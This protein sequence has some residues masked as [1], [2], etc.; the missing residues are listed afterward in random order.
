MLSYIRHADG[1]LTSMHDLA[2]KVGNRYI[3]AIFNPASNLDQKS[4]LRLVNPGTEV[5]DVTIR[6][7]DDRGTLSDS[8]V[9]LTVAARDSLTL[10]SEQ[11][12]SG[13]GVQGALGDHSGKWRLS[14]ESNRAIQV[15]SLLESPTKHLTNLS[16]SRGEGNNDVE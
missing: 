6:G 4:R 9:R 7:V 8:E 13:V 16:T 3:V 10:T 5:A 2:P 14:V 15:M 1:F 11:L 12:E